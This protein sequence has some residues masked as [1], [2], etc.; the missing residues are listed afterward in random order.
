MANPISKLFGD[1]KSGD[2]DLA[3]RVKDLKER[4]DSLKEKAGRALQ[5]SSKV[6]KEAARMVREM[7][8]LKVLCGRIAAT[9][10]ASLPPGSPFASVE[11][12]VFSQWGEDG[13][14]QHLIRHLAVEKSFIEF[15]VENYTEASTRFLLLNDNWRGLIMD[16]SE[17]N[18]ASVRQQDLYWRHD[19][20]AVAS[21]ITPENINEVIRG[22]G[23]AGKVG[24]LSVDIDGMDYWVLKAID[25]VE[26]AILICEYNSVFGPK[27][28]VTIP[29]DNSFTRSKAHHSNLFYG[30]SLAALDDLASQKGY[31]LVGVNSAGNNAF[32]VRR[33]I[34]SPFPRKQVQEVFVQAAFREARDEQ[35]ALTF[36]NGTQRRQAIQDCAAYDLGTQSIRPLRDVWR[37]AGDP[38]DES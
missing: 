7:E 23:F 18:M 4:F 19:L 15:G 24:L 9:S 30:A 35:G 5:H 27:A 21:F 38:L 12:Q 33:G 36:A 14:I 22:H 16:G 28:R 10:L 20:T 3:H 31:D 37:D 2:K 32:F 26:P 29:P 11:F 25:A 13:I 6:E 1:S 34:G 8:T 17:E